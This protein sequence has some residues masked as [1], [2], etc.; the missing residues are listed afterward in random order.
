MDFDNINAPILPWAKEFDDAIRQ[1]LLQHHHSK[2]INYLSINDSAS[3]AVPTWDHYIPLIYTIALEKPE[4][5]IRFTYEGFQY[6][7]ISMRCVQIG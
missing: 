3:I 6:G 1:H 2:L 5:T 4:D 7:S